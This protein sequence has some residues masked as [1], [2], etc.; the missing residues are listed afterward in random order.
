MHTYLPHLSNPQVRVGALFSFGMIL[1]R[2]CALTSV[3]CMLAPRLQQSPATVRQCLREICYEAK[4]KR[5]AKR[6]TRGVEEGFVCLLGWVLSWGEGTQI[7]LALD[8]TPLA[9]R[10]HG[11]GLRVVYRGGAIPVAWKL[12]P[13][14]QKH[15]WRPEWLRLLRLVHRAIPADK[16]LIVLADRGLYARGLFG[17]M[18][19]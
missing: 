15:A 19:A 18:C 4:R 6:V 2:S 9:D 1:A 14:E 7:A 8:A 12:L 11:L 13:A 5:G 10:F 16:T 17:R 3:A